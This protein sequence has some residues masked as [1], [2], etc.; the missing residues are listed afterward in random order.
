MKT[1]YITVFALLFI[2]TGAIAQQ[3][4]DIFSISYTYNPKVGLME[5]PGPDLDAADLD[6]SEFDVKLFLPL[7]LKNGSTTIINSL[8]WSF[9]NTFFNQL[10]ADYSF[11]AD[12]HAIQYTLG[13]NQQFNEKWGM[14]LLAKPTL[15]SNFKDGVSGGDFFMQGS[16][17]LHRK[18]NERLRIG[19]GA[20]YTNGFGEPKLVPLLNLRYRTE[21]LDLN[22]T[23]PVKIRATYTAGR[24]M[25]GLNAGLEGNQYNLQLGERD[26][27]AIEK[28]DAVKFSRYNIGPV[29]GYTIPGA[30]RLEVSAGLSLKRTFKVVDASNEEINFDLD[31]GLFV[32]TGFYFGK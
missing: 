16:A 24:L 31:N 32:K 15:A 1:L 19:A 21:K 20:A 25:L 7:Q 17:V 22:A 14:T 23:L 13:L 29:L 4:V 30:G 9:I 3:Q 5:P 27:P 2:T 11:E 28:V 12:L 26:L 18:I 8:E 10:P 6:V